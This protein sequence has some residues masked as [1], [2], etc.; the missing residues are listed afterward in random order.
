MNMR[1]L[2]FSAAFVLAISF[3]AS[4]ATRAQPAP[5]TKATRVLVLPVRDDGAGAQL[6]NTTASLVAVSLSKVPGYA[7][8]SA[9]DIKAAADV[10]ANRTML[11]C[12]QTSCLAEMAQAMG[13]DRV[14][15]GSITRLGKTLVIT[16]NLFDSATANGVGRE[17]LQVDDESTLPAAVESATRKLVGASANDGATSSTSRENGSSIGPVFLWSGV[18]LVGIGAIAG[19]AGAV[20][21]LGAHDVLTDPSALG[22]AKASAAEARPAW[23]IMTFAGVGAAALGAGLAGA[24]FV[25]E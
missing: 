3:V 9:D 14:V 25:M 19:T 13:A 6:A 11:G 10:D 1:T 18:A 16:L 17:T 22:D 12:D 8:L 7:V 15:H 21:G 2:F 23:A 20:L 5:A 4:T 24:S